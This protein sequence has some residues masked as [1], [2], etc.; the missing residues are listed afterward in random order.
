MIQGGERLGSPQ[1][2][3]GSANSS[4]VSDYAM[5]AAFIAP[6]I[7]LCMCVCVCVC[8]CVRY[9]CRCTT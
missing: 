5:M 2:L 7:G 9:V 8:V 4:E 3:D 1:N 6:K